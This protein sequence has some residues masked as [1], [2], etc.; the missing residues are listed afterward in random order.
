MLKRILFLF[1]LA[2]MASPL[3][4]SQITTSS[5]SGT[6]KGILMNPLSGQR[7]VAT[8]LPS[9]TKYATTSRGGGIFNIHNMRVGG[10]YLIEI[11]F[12]GYD[13]EKIENAFLQLGE[14]FSI[15]SVFKEN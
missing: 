13:A 11:T 7:S 10:P 6:V 5:I 1:V 2:F 8:H 9:G 15:K 12:V 14:S 4:F 3:L